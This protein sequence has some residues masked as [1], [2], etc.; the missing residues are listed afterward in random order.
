LDGVAAAYADILAASDID[1]VDPNRWADG[2]GIGF[3]GFAEWGWTAS[4]DALEAARMA[5]LRRLRDWEPRLRLLF[6]HATPTVSQRLDEGIGHLTR[7]LVRDDGGKDIPP[8]IAE[9][10]QTIKATVS[11]VRDL[12]GLLPSDD[13]PKRLVV[14]T[15]ALIDNP[16]AKIPRGG[17][18]R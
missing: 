3:V 12:T 15:N 7:W 4:D 1:N 14:D 6:P 17:S 9:A 16:D 8:T 5:L 13:Y 2:T 11:G 10:E 18:R